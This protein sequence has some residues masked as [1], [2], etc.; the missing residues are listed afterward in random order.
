MISAPSKNT[1]RD[2]E[3]K[4]IDLG[5]SGNMF[6]SATYKDTPIMGKYFQNIIF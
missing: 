6:N 5:F 2:N 1:G 4:K 3:E